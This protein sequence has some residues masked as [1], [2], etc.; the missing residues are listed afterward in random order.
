MASFPTSAKSFTLKANGGTIDASHV[1]DA[2]DEITAIEDGYLNGTAR[3]NSS[4]STLAS[5]SVAGGSTFAVRPV[6]P[7]PSFAKLTIDSTHTVGSSA[8]STIAW[9]SQSAV[10]NSSLHSTATNPE[11]FTPDS[12]GMWQLSVQVRTDSPSSLTR[13]VSIRDSSAAQFGQQRVTNSTAV[14]FNLA[15]EKRFDVIGGWFT[16]VFENPGVST[17]SLVAG[18]GNTWASL[19][20]L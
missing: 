16:V 8:E 3:L 11:R 20:K 19:R 6:M 1:N 15:C 10:L 5:L 9:L 14:T 12:T 2:Q 4:A 17:H 13:S 18:A 7:P